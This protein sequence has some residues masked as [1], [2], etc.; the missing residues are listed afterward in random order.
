MPLYLSLFGGVYMGLAGFNLKRR[1]ETE[2][3]KKQVENKDK[4]QPK[5]QSK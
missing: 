2:K 4:K 1:Q 5:K 3:V